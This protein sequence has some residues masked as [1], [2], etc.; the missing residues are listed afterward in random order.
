MVEEEED[1][2]E[3]EEEDGDPSELEEAAFPEL[4]ETPDIAAAVPVLPKKESRAGAR[5]QPSRS[6]CCTSKRAFTT[7]GTPGGG[8]GLSVTAVARRR[9][10]RRRRAIPRP[11]R[12]IA[13]LVSVREP[14]KPLL[15]LKTRGP[16]RT[17][18]SL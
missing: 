4:P 14:R 11:G 13:F 5:P 6:P 15:S 12:M 7:P 3:E 17:R 10:L 8:E 16:P 1:E 9:L 2:D 18:P